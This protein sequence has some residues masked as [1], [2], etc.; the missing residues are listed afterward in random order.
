MKRQWHLT[1]HRHVCLCAQR[2][3]SPL[4]ELVVVRLCQTPPF[5]LSAFRIN[6]LQFIA[7]EYRPPLSAA[8]RLYWPFRSQRVSNPLGAQAAG[9]CFVRLCG[10]GRMT[11]VWILRICCEEAGVADTGYSSAGKSVSARRRNQHARRVCY[12]ER[13]HAI[14]AAGT[15]A[16]LPVR[17]SGDFPRCKG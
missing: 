6:A 5:V 14:G 12:P 1:E 8:R 17:P 11:P 9:L 10:W 16:C 7:S 15:Q 4:Q 3:F 13:M 2:G